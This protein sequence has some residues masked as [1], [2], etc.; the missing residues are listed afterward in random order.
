MIFYKRFPGDYV[1]DTAHLSLV[2]H[3]AYS[4]MLDTYYSTGKPL[5]ADKPSLYRICKAMNQSERN[6]VDYVADQ[7]FPVSDD[8]L[9]HNKRADGEIERHG[10][11]VAINREIGNRGGRPKKTESVIESVIETETET[12]P[13]RNPSH[14]QSQITTKSSALSGKPDLPP[15]NG[16]KSE[17]LEVLAFLNEKAGRA[18]RP[19]DT[20]L[21]FIAARLKQGATV[22]DCKQVVAKKCREWK[23]SDMEPY[24]RPATL[25]N[26]TKFNQYVG[27]LVPIGGS[28]EQ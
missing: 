14:S 10:K 17:A 26:D 9:R 7:F 15:L 22:V 27:E 24:L 5:P 8:G 3:G 11:Q 25:F 28:N 18:Y 4:V 2:Q 13:N 16:K 21:R 1:R 20:N 6:A 19:T 23:G 12:E